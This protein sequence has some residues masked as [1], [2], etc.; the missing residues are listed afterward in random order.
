[1]GKHPLGHPV[2]SRSVLYPAPSWV[3]FCFPQ[4]DS[5][6]VRVPLPGNNPSL[7]LFSKLSTQLL[8]EGNGSRNLP[9]LPFVQ[10][11]NRT[12]YQAL[13]K[14]VSS[15]AGLTS[16]DLAPGDWLLQ[17]PLLLLPTGQVYASAN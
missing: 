7:L 14:A 12:H 6:K 8:G 9:P 3:D 4:D 10:L 13:T 1:M 16:P 17:S 11:Q 2:I 5:S 15:W